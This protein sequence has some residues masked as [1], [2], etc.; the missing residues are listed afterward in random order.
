M[1]VRAITKALKGKGWLL[2]HEANVKL[3]QA[4]K[5]HAPEARGCERGRAPTSLETSA[6]TNTS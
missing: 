2:H 3:F 1:Q 6:A 5:Y 4:F